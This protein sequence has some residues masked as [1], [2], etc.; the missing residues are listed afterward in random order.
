MTKPI[1]ITR[2]LS[3]AS[4]FG[5]KLMQQGFEV[6]YL[7]VIKTVVVD[8]DPEFDKE[9]KDIESYDWIFLTSKNAV[10]FFHERATTLGV[11]LE[12]EG[13][14]KPPQFATVGNATADYMESFGLWANFV[15]DKN[16][17][18]GLLEEFKTL[19]FKGKKCL[20]ASSNIADDKLSLGLDALGAKVNKFVSYLTVADSELATSEKL[21]E[22][23]EG[24]FSCVCFFSPSSFEFLH[25]ADSECIKAHVAAGGKTAAI[26]RTTARA[27]VAAD[28][29]PDIIPGNSN[30]KSLIKYIKKAF[31]SD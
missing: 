23:T 18:D 11:S 5:E 12:F 1:L 22:L 10:K 30:Q 2:P 7:P 25:K 16:N 13:V 19:D 4:I 9:L 3:D 21:K 14:K 28:I 24:K 8:N 27:L 17:I 6:D 31:A 20:L 15:P 29:E 26:G